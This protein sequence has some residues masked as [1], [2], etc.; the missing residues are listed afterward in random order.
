MRR[1]RRYSRAFQIWPW[2]LILSSVLQESKEACEKDLEI[3]EGGPTAWAQ[4]PAG[5]PRATLI[6]ASE[7][8]TAHHTRSMSYVAI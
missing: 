5:M 1:D 2:E 3:N 4:D 8:L 7:S 6:R